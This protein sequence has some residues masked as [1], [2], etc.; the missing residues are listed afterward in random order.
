MKIG[1][2]GLGG[3][4]RCMAL[5]AISAGHQLTAY[6]RGA[7]KE[8]IAAKGAVLTGDYAELAANCE[9]LCLCV[10]S[11]S[12]LREV[13]F[14]N[15]TL[16]AM[17]PGSIVVIH[18]TGSP[19]LTREI[20]ERAP[21]GVSVL[22]AC[23]SG[24]PEDTLRGEL[25]LMVGGD[26]DALKT[27]RPVLSTYA[28]RIH[29]V[30]PLGAGQLL[31]LLN[32]L[33]FATNLKQAAEIIG[34]ATEQGL[35]PRLA[36]KVICQSSG[37]SMAMGLLENSGVEDMLNSSRSYMKKDVQTAFDAAN[38]TG[39]DIATFTPVLDFYC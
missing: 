13:L 34:I 18:T 16:A 36:A 39:I 6:D 20:G 33:L 8:E 4:G 31:K 37:G 26:D 24:G 15:G 17:K 28:S 14:D 38:E 9:A 35:D 5:R 10:F 25:T 30:G 3:I 1:W 11:D 22:D 32:N 21:E 19:A 23:F 29:K 27:V 7:G 12:Q 2:I